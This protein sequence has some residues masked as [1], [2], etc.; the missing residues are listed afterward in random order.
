[1]LKLSFTGNTLQECFDQMQEVLHQQNPITIPGKMNPPTAVNPTPP[2]TVTA[3][4]TPTYDAPTQAAPTIP[5]TPPAV[6]I[7]TPPV[8][9]APTQTATPPVAAPTY[10]LEQLSNA[11]AMLVQAGKMN[12]CIALVNQLG[13][14]TFAQVTPDQYGTLATGLRALGAQL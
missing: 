11:G 8:N 3:A 5:Q 9:S 2:V 7:A 1:M 6:P 4:V 10:T 12:E 14:E 13:H